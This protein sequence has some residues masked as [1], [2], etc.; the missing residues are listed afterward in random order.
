MNVFREFEPD[1]AHMSSLLNKTTKTVS[2]RSFPNKPATR[3][4]LWERWKKNAFCAAPSTFA[5]QIFRRHVRMW[6]ATGLCPCL[7]AART[8]H[9][10]HSDM[11]PYVIWRWMGTRQ[12]TQGMF[13]IS[14]SSAVLGTL[15]WGLPI[16]RRYWSRWPQIDHELFILYW[17]DSSLATTPTEVWL[18]GGQHFWQQTSNIRP[19]VADKIEE[20]QRDAWT[21]R[22]PGASDHYLWFL[23][24]KGRGFHIWKIM[25][26]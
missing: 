19:D 23:K 7:K 20:N 25:V 9:L 11:R 13:W 10:K 14:M 3:Q 2:C 16:N 26:P 22:I 4:P 1:I 8:D 24:K 21:R 17:N 18:R 12:N 6:Q 15:P 5:R